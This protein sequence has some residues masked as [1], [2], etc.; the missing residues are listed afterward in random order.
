M[1]T[2]YVI[3]IVAYF[4]HHAFGVWYS[5]WALLYCSNQTCDAGSIASHRFGGRLLRHQSLSTVIK[6]QGTLGRHC[7]G[8]AAQAPGSSQ[9]SRGDGVKE[10]RDHRVQEVCM[11]TQFNF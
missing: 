10:D 4:T 1:F 11:V 7:Y 8:D 3:V 9:R 6:Q 2:F 5:Q